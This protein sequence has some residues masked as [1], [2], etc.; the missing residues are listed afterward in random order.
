MTVIGGV[1]CLK[2][3]VIYKR[4]T[5]SVVTS[6]WSRIMDTSNTPNITVGDKQQK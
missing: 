6:E 2:A 1:F 4:K 3:R 5:L